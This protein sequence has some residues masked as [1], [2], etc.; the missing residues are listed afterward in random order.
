MHDSHS[1]RLIS[2]PELCIEFD[3]SLSTLDRRF[4]KTGLLKTTKVGATRYSTP[5]WLD[6]CYERIKAQAEEAA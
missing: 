2:I 3:V 1:K 5:E 6:A 4:L